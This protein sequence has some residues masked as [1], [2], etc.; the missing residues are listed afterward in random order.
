MDLRRARRFACLAGRRFGLG[1]A[2]LDAPERR[3]G[4]RLVPR[5]RQRDAEARVDD[6]GAG[7][8]NFQEEA[9][10]L[11]IDVTSIDNYSWNFAEDAKV[12]IIRRDFR[13]GSGL[14]AQEYDLVVGRAAIEVMIHDLGELVQ[15]FREAKRVLK[16]GGEFRFGPG[17]LEIDRI[18]TMKPVDKTRL[19]RYQK[20]LQ[21]GETLSAQAQKDLSCLQI[22]SDIEKELAIKFPWKTQE[23][24][25]EYWLDEKYDKDVREAN[26]AIMHRLM[27]DLQIE[28]RKAEKQNYEDDMSNSYYV[29]KKP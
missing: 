5:P 15:V 27:P 11:G 10:K 19:K 16:H 4:A 14:P 17:I 24:L 18:N 9:E 8:A 7:A 3:D 28:I 2:T 22:Q 20:R 6:V 25:D 26:L 21:K 13:Q 12:P 29:I 23:D 1:R